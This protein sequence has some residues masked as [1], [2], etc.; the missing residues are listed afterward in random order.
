MMS[1]IVQVSRNRAAALGPVLA[2]AFVD[3]PVWE[4]LVPQDTARRLALLF[5]RYL[6]EQ[7][8]DGRVFCDS[9]ETVVAIWCQ[10]GERERP[11]Q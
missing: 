8:K 2:S 6:E 10:S 3:D 7:A 4:W 11:R 9:A 1:E 5:S